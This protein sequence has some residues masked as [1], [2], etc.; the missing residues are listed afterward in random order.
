MRALCNWNQ[1]EDGRWPYLSQFLGELERIRRA[2]SAQELERS[3]W[4]RRIKQQEPPEKSLR[5]P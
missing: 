3:F 5:Q 2:S 4:D 1:N